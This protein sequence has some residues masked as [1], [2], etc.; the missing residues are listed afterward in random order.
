MQSATTSQRRVKE[1]QKWKETCWCNEKCIVSFYDYEELFSRCFHIQFLKTSHDANEE[2]SSFH[3][4]N[5][6]DDDAAAFFSMEN[7]LKFPSLS[8]DCSRPD[9]SYHF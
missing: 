3:C 1:W 7:G 8:R 2:R 6:D 4:F 9:C 5:A